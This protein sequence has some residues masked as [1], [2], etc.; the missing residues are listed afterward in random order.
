MSPLATEGLA[1]PAEPRQSHFN[2]QDASKIGV[3]SSSVHH[4][5]TNRPATPGIDLPITWDVHPRFPYFPPDREAVIYRHQFWSAHRQKIWDALNTIGAGANRLR[6]FHSC[7]TGVW[8]YKSADG[9]D[10]SLRCS[11]CH[12]RACQACAR[13]RSK[14]ISANIEAHLSGRTTRFLTVT[15]KHSRLSYKSQIDRLYRSFS[16]FRRRKDFRDHVIGGVA[17]FEGKLGRDGLLHPHMHLIIEGSF[18]SQYDIRKAWHEVTG[19][20]WIVDIQAKGDDRS[21]AHYLSKYI[22]KPISDDFFLH[23][24]KLAEFLLAIKGRRMAFCFGTWRKVLKLLER[25]DDDT[26]WVPLGSLSQLASNAAAGD[27]EAR[28][29]L[30]AAIRKWPSLG[31]Y[32]PH[33]TPPDFDAA[34]P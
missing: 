16:A 12:D 2:M 24:E 31:Q 7:G 3:F 1:A 18:W 26:D 9:K 11:C 10:I 34:P 30:E 14:L 25:D 27:P 15:L 21:K 29:F 28:R 4:L 13:G 32:H 8:L 6:R 22:T 33:P 17:A 20:S 19:D 23:P 5:Q